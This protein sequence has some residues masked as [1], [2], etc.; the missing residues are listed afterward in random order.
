MKIVLWLFLLSAS[1]IPAQTTHS[2]TLTWQDSNP[3]TP[4]VTWNVK[5]AS[6]ACTGTPAF[7]TIA[8]ALTVKTY[9]DTTVAIATY[10][11]IVT[12]VVSGVETLPSNQAGANI[13]PFAPSRL[14]VTVR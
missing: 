11:Y 4:P 13:L 7:T 10:C 12:A 3:T 5:R 9:V 14:S 8:T 6:G 2:V 1:L